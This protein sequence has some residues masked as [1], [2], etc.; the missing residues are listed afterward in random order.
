M[1]VIDVLK[2]TV[3]TMN[4][5]NENLAALNKAIEII[6]DKHNELS[7]NAKNI[8][9]AYTITC[10]S[11]DVLITNVLEYIK[12]NGTLINENMKTCNAKLRAMLEASE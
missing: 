4:T 2:D 3:L 8:E 1:S 6:T 10:A 5:I 11:L 7:K 12:A 9:E